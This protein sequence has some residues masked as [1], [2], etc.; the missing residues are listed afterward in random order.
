MR[1]VAMG[2]EVRPRTPRGFTLVICWVPLR[3]TGFQEKSCLFQV[4]VDGSR[5][6]P[7]N[8]ILLGDGD[9]KKDITSRFDHRTQKVK[10]VWPSGLLDETRN[11]T[12]TWITRQPNTAEGGQKIT[13]VSEFNDFDPVKTSATVHIHCKSILTE[14]SARI[15]IC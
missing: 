10:Q 13:C 15:S 3:P 9:D 6:K 1:L 5:K 2:P 14:A 7:N 11:D 8:R 4:F 12:Y